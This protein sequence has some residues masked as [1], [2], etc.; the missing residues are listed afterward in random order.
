M[1]SRY[2]GVL[3]LQFATNLNKWILIYRISER[4]GQSL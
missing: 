1:T 2:K 3:N 4:Q